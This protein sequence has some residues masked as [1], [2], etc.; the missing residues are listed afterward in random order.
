MKLQLLQTFT[1]ARIVI[2]DIEDIFSPIFIIL[3]VLERKS[4]WF[5]GKNPQSIKESTNLYNRRRGNTET[6]NRID[7]VDG[8]S[9]TP[10][11]AFPDTKSQDSDVVAMTKQFT[12]GSLGCDFRNQTVD[13]QHPIGVKRSES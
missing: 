11:R 2:P 10:R 6:A 9:H 3:F 8:I 13:R 1:E 5:F 4:F 12:L 7:T